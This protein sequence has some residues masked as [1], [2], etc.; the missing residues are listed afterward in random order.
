MFSELKNIARIAACTKSGGENGR[1][2]GGFRV[3]DGGWEV[4]NKN[5]S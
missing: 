5:L 3:R 1:R 4:I 2:R